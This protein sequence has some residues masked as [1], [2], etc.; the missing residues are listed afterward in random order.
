M[1]LFSELENYALYQAELNEI[2]KK[3]NHEIFEVPEQNE[4]S[5]RRTVILP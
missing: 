5:R 2:K 3:E 4:N 1:L